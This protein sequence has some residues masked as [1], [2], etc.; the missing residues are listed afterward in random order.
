MEYVEAAL[1]AEGCWTKIDLSSS[2]NNNMAQSHVVGI[3]LAWCSHLKELRIDRRKNMVTNSQLQQ[4]LS[5]SPELRSLHSSHRFSM[6][7]IDKN[8][9]LHARD[10]LQGQ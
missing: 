10:A 5:Q 6:K 2:V 4:F 1:A 8:P 7:D 9:I 3:V